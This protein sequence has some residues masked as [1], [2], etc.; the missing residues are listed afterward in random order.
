MSGLLT[1][2]SIR[3]KLIMAFALILCGTI[4]LG[5]FAVQRLNRVSASAAD[6]RDNWLPATRALGDMGRFAEQIRVQP[7]L[8]LLAVVP[9]DRDLVTATIQDRTKL[10][11]EQFDKYEATV[12]LDGPDII[13]E[14][15]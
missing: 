3:A 7:Q 6:L 5:L 9:A 13:T 12:A 10:F 4:S 14:E 11:N 15:T 2:F 1:R 8:Q